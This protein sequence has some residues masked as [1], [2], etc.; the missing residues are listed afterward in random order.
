[1][2]DDLGNELLMQMIDMNGSA[3]EA[4]SQTEVNDDTDKLLAGFINGTFFTVD[5]FAFGLNIDDQDPTS[6][7]ANIGG[8]AGVLSTSPTRQAGSQVKFGNWKR[9][10]K[11][12][13]E[14]IPP[15]PVRMD[16]FAVTR[17]FD[18]ASPV[19]FQ[20]CARSTSFKS[21]V[22]VK[23]K[24]IGKAMLKTFLRMEFKD[25]L[26]THV[27][28]DDAEVIK[29]TMRFVFR[30]VTLQYRQQSHDGSLLKAAGSVSWNYK[31]DLRK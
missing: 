25:V 12:D 3:I 1:M 22:L 26:V 16:E 5:D 14:K 23:R 30:G 28:W 29:E 10:K 31:A 19:L 20:S 2:A 13:L 15:F 24:I 6:D 27:G 18:R 4:E 8:K 21:A 17:A 9:W 7:A 11:G